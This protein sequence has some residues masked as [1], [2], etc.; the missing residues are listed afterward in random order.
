MGIFR[1]DDFFE[2]KTAGFV[3]Q[4]V[5]GLFSDLDK[6]DAC[7]LA[8]FLFFWDVKNCCL[9]GKIFGKDDRLFAFIFRFSPDMG[10]DSF[11]LWITLF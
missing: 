4:L 5:G 11:C 1:P 10:C 7:L 6:S 8:D 3:G 9:N 2:V